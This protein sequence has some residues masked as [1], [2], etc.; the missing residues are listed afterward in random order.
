[1]EW[2]IY[3]KFVQFTLGSELCYFKKYTFLLTFRESGREKKRE[4]LIS[5]L[6]HSPY[7]RSQP[8]HQTGNLLVH[9][10]M[11]N[12]LSHTGQDRIILFF[13]G[14]NWLV[15]INETLLINTILFQWFLLLLE[16]NSQKEIIRNQAIDV[17]VKSQ[18]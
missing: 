15:I 5:C 8:E 7:W 1:M 14:E 2:Y 4:T 18:N 6:L 17:R 13:I 3:L 12:Q 10:A 11:P 16:H 9:V